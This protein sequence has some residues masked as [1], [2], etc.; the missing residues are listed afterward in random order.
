ME[1]ITAIIVAA[2]N[3]TRMG[4]VKNKVF[5]PLGEQSVIDYTLNTI[6]KCEE[7]DNIILVTRECDIPLCKNLKSMAKN[8]LVIAGGKTRQESVYLGLQAAKNA[9]IVVIHDGARALITTDIIK[10]AIDNTKKFG[11]S[12]VG[13]PCKDTLKS[14]DEDGF[15]TGTID[16]EHTYLIQTPQ[17]FRKDEILLAHKK[18]IKDRFIATDDCALYEKYIGKIKITMGSYDNIKLTTP[19]DMVI[20]KN[21]LK[22]S[23]L[24]KV[25]NKRR[26]IKNSIKLIVQKHIISS[27]IKKEKKEREKWE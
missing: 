27:S 2:G 5:L 3:G 6:S 24:L 1:K 16:R 7:I 23:G 21:I 8:I 22:N 15:I 12:A 4:G 9:D 10:N 26:S 20:A 11:A 17:I 18:A 19:D 13:V 14:V 25:L